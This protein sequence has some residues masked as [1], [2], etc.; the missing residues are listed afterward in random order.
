MKQ[1]TKN[2]LHWIL[3]FI[4]ITI[5]F[6]P[7]NDHRCTRQTAT[8]LNSREVPTYCMLS[9]YS[10]WLYSTL[11][12]FATG[13][14][15]N[16]SPPNALSRVNLVPWD[17]CGPQGECEFRYVAVGRGRSAYCS[18]LSRGFGSSLSFIDFTCFS[19][20]SISSDWALWNSSRGGR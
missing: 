1:K 13:H 2:N 10:W 14:I 8:Q 17:C 3:S 5:L 15:R 20:L 7:K 16:A 18:G 12:T 19:I 4:H 11:P 9:I 6:L